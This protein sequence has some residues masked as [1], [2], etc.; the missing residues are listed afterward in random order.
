MPSIYDDPEVRMNS[1][2]VKFENV[3]DS[4]TG[5]I[6]S[7]GKHTF[8]D[9]KVAIKY[10]IATDDGDKTLTA[11]QFQLKQKLMDVRP[12]VGDKVHI[13]HTGVLKLTGGKTL[14]EFDVKKKPGEKQP[15]EDPF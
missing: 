9:G 11:S 5:T 8:D 2:Y 6:L 15:E 13:Q 4:V 7:I 3:G 14:K 10:L 12:E 1:D